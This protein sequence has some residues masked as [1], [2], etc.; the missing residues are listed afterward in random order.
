MVLS[1]I[2]RLLIVNLFP[3]QGK[4]IAYQKAASVIRHKVGLSAEELQEYEVTNDEGRVTW[5]PDLPQETDIDLTGAEIG[6]I[7]TELKE[8]DDND[9]LTADHI[10][11]W[12]KF[13]EE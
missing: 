1:I 5:R 2:E 8:Q 10:T 11:L 3:L 6:M 12:N 7:A 9:A 4:K 13:I